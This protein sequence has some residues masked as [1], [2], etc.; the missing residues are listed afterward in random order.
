MKRTS[1][2]S[3]S[4]YDSQT[5]AKVVALEDRSVLGEEGAERQGGGGDGL[6]VAPDEGAGYAVGVSPSD[7][8]V[9]IGAVDG[10][11]VLHCV[12]RGAWSP[13]TEV[14]LWKVSARTFGAEGGAGLFSVALR[15][16]LDE[17]LEVFA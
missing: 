17:L 10:P 16:G 12:P 14:A 8:G 11:A 2:S 1:R 5:G 7:D 13:T 9:G 6:D 15:G 3:S 4:K